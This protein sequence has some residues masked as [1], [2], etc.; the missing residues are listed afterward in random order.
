M[1][2]LVKDRNIAQELL[3][4]LSGDEWLDRNEIAAAMGKK[5]LNPNEVRHLEELVE[6]ELVERNEVLSGIASKFV[7]RKA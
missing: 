7:Y 1:Y 3:E 2:P 6:S 4:A 5:R